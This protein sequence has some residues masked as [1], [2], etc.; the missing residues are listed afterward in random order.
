M[1][2]VGAANVATA[3]TAA[4]FHAVRAANIAATTTAVCTVRAAN[5]APTATAIVR[6]LCAV[7]PGAVPILGGITCCAIWA[8][9]IAATA[10]A[11][12][13]VLGKRVSLDAKRAVNGFY[14]ALDCIA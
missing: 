12:I 2:L 8:A 4:S 10:T 3:A 9:N 7:G 13:G 6:S 14:F 11:A 5:I 1:F